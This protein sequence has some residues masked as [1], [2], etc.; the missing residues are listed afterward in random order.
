[1]ELAS[2]ENVGEYSC[3]YTT[4]E[5]GK[6]DKRKEETQK[7]REEA[8]REEGMR[9]ETTHS[10]KQRVAKKHARTDKSDTEKDTEGGGVAGTSQ[11]QSRHRKG[12]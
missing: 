6:G 1:M 4:K 3:C 10:A 2:C 9:E 7:K 5:G 11:S 12:T 8:R